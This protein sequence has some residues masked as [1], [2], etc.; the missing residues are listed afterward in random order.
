LIASEKSRV[1]TRKA[2]APLGSN[3]VIEM[4][5]F[6]SLV[7]AQRIGDLSRSADLGAA[8]G[9]GPQS[10]VLAKNIF[11][12]TGLGRLTERYCKCTRSYSEA[13]LGTSGLCSVAAGCFR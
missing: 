11:L 10:A 4:L 3:N 7:K 1:L 6:R 5:K 9:E 8:R 2:L 13:S 12:P